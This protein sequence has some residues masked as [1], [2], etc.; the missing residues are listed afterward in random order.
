MAGIYVHIP[1]CKSRCIY[2]GFYSTTMMAMRD[3]YVE[4]LCKEM[5][6]RKDYISEQFS[7]IYIGGGTPSVLTDKQL[8]KIFNNI[9]DKFSIE[10]NA[11]VTIECNPDDITLEFAEFLKTMPINRISMGVQTFSEK[12]LRFLHRR[13]NVEEVRNAVKFL[14]R[15][16]MRNIS[17]DL[18]FGFPGETLNEWQRDITEALKLDVEHISAYSLM[19]E[20]GTVLGNMLE[21]GDVKEV[22]DELSL[23]MYDEL[24]DRLTSSGYEH[25]EISNFAKKGYRSRHNSSYWKQ[26]PYIGIGAAA[27]SYNISSRQWNVSNIEK[28]IED[29]CK[30]SIPMEQEGLDEDTKV[31]DLITTALRT[32]EGIDLKNVETQY[33]VKYKDYILRCAKRHIETR[34]LEINESY[35]RLTRKGIY[36]SNTIMSDLMIV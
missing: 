33:G 11:E 2:C 25:Y 13:H 26:V 36:V 1:F 20:E 3:K 21:K 34:L 12:R 18:I 28:Y 19:Y 23:A 24:T 16:G 15:A 29:I 32:C 30:G 4:A 7:T 6:L 8:E 27:H 31:N 35:L 17:I 22:S 14:R 5:E 9:F 10:N